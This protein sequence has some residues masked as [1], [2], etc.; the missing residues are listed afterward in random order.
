[1]HS[2]RSKIPNKGK[3]MI[4]LKIH[5]EGVISL[6]DSDLIGKT[7][8]EGDLQLEMSERFYK[9]EEAAR[10][11]I[12]EALKNAKTI[13]IVG[14]ESIKLALEEKMITKDAIRK[15]GGTPHA[16]VFFM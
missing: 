6:C 11:E 2:M 10:E 7:F 16:Q 12:V 5:S 1:M 13:N 3:N 4:Q 8:E 15:I 9:G 14:E